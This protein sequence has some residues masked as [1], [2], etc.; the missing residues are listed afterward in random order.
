[1][2][3]EF[4]TIKASQLE[5]L[6]EVTD[7]NY[8]VVTDGA[9]SKKVKATNLCF[10]WSHVFLVFVRRKLWKGCVTN[11]RRVDSAFLLKQMQPSV[12][13]FCYVLRLCLNYFSRSLGVRLASLGAT[14]IPPDFLKK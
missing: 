10:V 8:V 9:T 7:S 6:T 14:W 1:M 11:C 5:E 12:L 4:Q 2:A 3:N 13:G